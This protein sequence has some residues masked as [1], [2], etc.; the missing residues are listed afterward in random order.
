M[1]VYYRRDTLLGVWSVCSPYS[2]ARMGRVCAVPIDC[3]AIR[4]EHRDV[5]CLMILWSDAAPAAPGSAGS[6]KEVF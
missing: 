4:R 2:K 6:C 1:I 3:I 5:I